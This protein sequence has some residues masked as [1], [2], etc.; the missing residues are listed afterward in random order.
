MV[1]ADRNI[2]EGIWLSELVQQMEVASLE[3]D[4]MMDGVDEGVQL[5]SASSKDPRAVQQEK[6]QG[7]LLQD[8][9]QSILLQLEQGTLPV[10]EHALV[11]LGLKPA[12]AF[13]EN[14]RVVREGDCEDWFFDVNR[15]S[16]LGLNFMD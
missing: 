8:T 15:F 13:D 4:V 5:H 14:L 1:D 16:S 9:L 10:L 6:L 7:L 2:C 12:F 3:A 11:T